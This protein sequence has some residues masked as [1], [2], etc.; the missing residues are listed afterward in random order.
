M[1][2]GR[3]A[4]AEDEDSQFI[5]RSCQRKFSTS[6]SLRAAA[7]NVD[8]GRS[9]YFF[10]IGTSRGLNILTISS[11]QVEVVDLRCWRRAHNMGILLE[12][13]GVAA[14]WNNTR[15]CCATSMAKPES[16]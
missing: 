3:P 14:I 15:I 11:V 6:P 8:K 2:S 5:C 4:G 9:A 13:H 7:E 10:Q 12:G 16:A 1:G